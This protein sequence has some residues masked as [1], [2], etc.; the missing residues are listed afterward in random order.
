MSREIIVNEKKNTIEISK[1][2]A[3]E[4]KVF[5]TDEYKNLQEVRRDYPQFKVAVKSIS[6][7][8]DSFKGLTLDYMKNYIRKNDTEEML[9]A[10]YLATKIM[11]PCFLAISSEASD[12]MKWHA[13]RRDTERH[14]KDFFRDISTKP[15]VA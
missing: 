10:F 12:R 5:G 13:M 14:L 6:K 8:K 3:K 11:T 7:K 2:F 1:A 15:K 4:A 9:K